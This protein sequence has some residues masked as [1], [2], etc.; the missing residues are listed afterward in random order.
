MWHRPFPAASRPALPRAPSP[1]SPFALPKRALA[2][3]IPGASGDS[4]SERGGRASGRPAEGGTAPGRQ[5]GVGLRRYRC[6]VD[7]P[8]TRTWRPDWPCPVEQVWGSF[9][10][11]VTDP[12]YRVHAGFHWRALNSPSGP[13]TLAVRPLDAA[14]LIEGRA[15][16]PGAELVLDHASRPARRVRRPVRLRAAAPAAGRTAPAPS[17]LAAGAHAVHLGRPRAGGDR[18]EGHRA[19]G[20]DGHPVAARTSRAAGARPGCS[21]RPAHLPHARGGPGD[22]VLGVAGA[23]HR[24]GPQPHHRQRRPRGRHPRTRA[25]GGA[26]PVRTSGCAAFPASASGR[27][28]RSGHGPSATRTR[29]ASATTTWPRT[30]AGH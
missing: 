28:R 5:P 1:S 26:R 30:S 22:P 24:P 8:R 15:W 4:G 9:K 6:R 14:G 16:G 2:P 18:A 27:A 10:R 29:S 11:G 19:G 7:E 23:A 20:D 25:A 13:A 21:A 3:G 12:T 17:A